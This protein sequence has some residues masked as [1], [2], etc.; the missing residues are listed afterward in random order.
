LQLFDQVVYRYT[1]GQAIHDRV[2][3]PYRFVPTD[4]DLTIDEA[5]LDL[6]LAYRHL[7]PTVVSSDTIA[8]AEAFR[9]VLE[10]H[11]VTVDVIH[12]RRPP[13]ERD[14][15]IE[16]LRTGEVEVVVHVRMLS[17]GVDFPWLRVICLRARR[18]SPVLFMQEFGRVLRTLKEPDHWGE[19]RQGVIL[20]PHDLFGHHNLAHEPMLGM[21]DPQPETAANRPDPDDE[22]EQ[23]QGGFGFDDDE[24]DMA[25]AVGPVE[26]WARSLCQALAAQGVRVRQRK[27]PR[28]IRALEPSK[29][30]Q[31]YLRG[32]TERLSGDLPDVHRRTLLFLVHERPEA[33]S[34]GACSD[35]ISALQGAK[36]AGGWPEH[37][38]VHTL[39][40]DA[41]GAA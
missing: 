11:D 26:Q 34:R 27:E 39:E 2:L 21:P 16:R 17:E 22:V 4:D 12:S 8:D 14:E 24:P 32:L 1:L 18:A 5:C 36:D 40:L 30:Q 41:V 20:D 29:S 33:F 7:G 35:L 23:H 31:T 13:T 25:V 37:L 6:V 38:W 19:K 15:A 9:T 28:D 3:V 10:E